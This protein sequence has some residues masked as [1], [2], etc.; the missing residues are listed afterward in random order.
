[1][2]SRWFLR[3]G[4]ARGLVGQH[5]QQQTCSSSSWPRLTYDKAQ[6]L[7]PRDH[8]DIC[9][10]PARVQARRRGGRRLVPRQWWS[11]TL[12]QIMPRLGGPAAVASE[13]AQSLVRTIAETKGRRVCHGMACMGGRAS[14]RQFIGRRKARESRPGN[15]AGRGTQGARTLLSIRGERRHAQCRCRNV[16]A[17]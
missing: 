15:E 8:T 9:Q 6:V 2:V 3:T 13:Q 17:G 5:R 16:G 14:K 1:M 7:A 12:V 10:F 4:K 11:A